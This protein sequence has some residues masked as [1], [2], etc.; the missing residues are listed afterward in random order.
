MAN[1]V[2][3][4]EDKFEKKTTYTTTKELSL[5]ANFVSW[6]LKLQL[7]RL[8]MMPDQDSMLIDIS[9]HGLNNGRWLNLDEGKLII[10]VDDE[11]IILPAHTN[12]AR[13][14]RMGNA[15]E[16]CY[17][18]LEKSNLTRICNCRSIS[19]KVYVDNGG[20]EVDNSNAFAVY[21]KL[22]YNAVYDNT[23]YTD[24]AEKALGEF[25]KQN[26]NT[27]SN[28]KL[29]GSD[30]KEGGC[31]GMLALMITMAGAAIGGICSLI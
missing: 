2:T 24:V 10:L 9:S 11:T 23:A 19:M 13:H 30:A 4:E 8:V 22:F 28:I 21:C 12:Y 20:V 17:Y 26:Y 27:F 18:E 7:R 29:D 3:I 15:E 14:D 1:F 31:M 16:S 5:G 6:D 25:T